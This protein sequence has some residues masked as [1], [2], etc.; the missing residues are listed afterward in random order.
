MKWWMS[1]W[2]ALAVVW[3][4][5]AATV[6]FDVQPDALRIGEAAEMTVTV[7]GIDNPPAPELPNIPGLRFS[8]PA[9]EHS[10]SMSM[11][12][13]GSSQQERAVTYRYRIIP[14]QPGEYIVGPLTYTV[15]GQSV[16]LPARPLKVVSPGAAPEQETR[17]ELSDLLFA[18]VTVERPSVY[19][20]EVFDLTISIYSRGLNLARDVSLMNMPDTGLV[21]QGFQE[22][23]T[24]REVVR[25]DVYDVRRFR[26]KVRGLNAG[27]L[28]FE[29]TLRVNLLVPRNDR[30]RGSLFDDQFFGGI[31]S[32]TEMHPIEIKPERLT[33]RV[34]PLPDAD[35][36]A[37]FSGAVGQFAMDV[38]VSPTQTSVGD[39]V[40]IQM[41]VSGRGNIDV[42]PAPQIELGQ[43]FRTYPVR[44][45]NKE[46]DG[47]QLAG[48][49]VF[50]QIIIPRSEE[51]QEVPEVLFSYFNP[52]TERY[53]I[54]RRGPTPLTVQAADSAPARVVAADTA[55]GDPRAQVIGTDILYLKPLPPRWQPAQG[56]PWYL[57]PAFLGAQGVPPLVLLALLLY[58]MRRKELDRNIAK[59]R[60]QRAPRSARAGLRAAEHALRKRHRG[61]FFGAIWTALTSYFGD[62]L[63]LAPGE[64][65]PDQVL[66]LIERQDMAAERL[67]ELRGLFAL[68][69]EERF[70]LSTRDD[71]PIS[72][73][74]LNAHRE[75]L[76]RLNR[77]LRACEKHARN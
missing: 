29:P 76:D 22:Q 55:P 16:E 21:L 66:A 27:A 7:R 75:Q 23:R 9:V 40:T 39:P 60:R 5:L 3:T 20:Q 47:Q 18:T 43:D 63:N 46:I 59:A 71:V 72:D 49:K 14:L 13:G 1:V 24:T 33:V 31:F 70:G 56:R 38:S 48:R 41:A 11:G 26:T 65:T 57:R 54:I 68:C 6:Q 19:V 51:I 32:Q 45:I 53:E 12:P 35:R 58:A 67:D 61:E 52:E 28:T 50:E 42:A 44:M 10:Y 2:M 62:R 25:N 69:E 36:P 73:E 77:I 37:D 8:G 15:Q 34:K 74:E 30:R 17:Q 4:S 64:V